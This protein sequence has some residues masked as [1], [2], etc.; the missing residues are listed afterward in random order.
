MTS[1]V[2]DDRWESTGLTGMNAE[3]GEVLEQEFDGARLHMLRE[4]VLTYATAAGMREDRAVEVMLA[5]HELAANAVRH[6]AGSGRLRMHAAV[7]ALHCEVSDVGPASHNGGAG[8]QPWPCRRGHGLWLVQQAA[9]Q[10]SMT[11]GPQGSQITV[12]FAA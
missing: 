2:K 4:L 3:A 7:K 12:V 6:G 10:V 11:S 1:V 5:V 8:T 9:D